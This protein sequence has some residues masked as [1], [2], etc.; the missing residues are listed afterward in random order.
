MN[1]S[2]LKDTIFEMINVD[3][4]ITGIALKATGKVF[5]LMNLVVVYPNDQEL[6]YEVRKLINQWKDEDVRGSFQ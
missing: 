2:E 5:D 1:Q 6:G 4:K 3:G